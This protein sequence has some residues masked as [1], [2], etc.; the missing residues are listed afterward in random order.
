M[1]VE[2]VTITAILVAIFF[3]FLRG[4][5]PK[6]ALST[7]PLIIV[8]VLH[9]LGNPLSSWLSPMLGLPRLSVYVAVDVIAFVLFL[10][11]SLFMLK[12]F[13]SRRTKVTYLIAGGLFTLAL[14]VILISD[15]LA[16]FA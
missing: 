12:N 5:K 2:C 14:S 16:R 15:M 8:P 7:V 13:H 11:L 3:V 9:L 6:S 10:G 1:I 4:H